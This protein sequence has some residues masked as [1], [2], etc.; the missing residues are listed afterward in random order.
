MPIWLLHRGMFDNYVHMCKQQFLCD[1]V[2]HLF[3]R[4]HIEEKQKHYIHG[5]VDKSSL[6][7][8]FCKIDGDY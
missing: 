3:I 1:R 4:D 5:A 6:V 8:Q 2:S 7:Q